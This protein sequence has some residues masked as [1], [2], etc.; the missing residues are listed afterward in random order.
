M[1]LAAPPL[2][3]RYPWGWRRRDSLALLLPM[4]EGVLVID[5]PLGTEL[6]ARGVPTPLPGWSAHALETHPEVVE[7]VHRDYARAGAR[8]HTTNTFRTRSRV[9]PQQ[10]ELLARRAVELARRAVC[11]GQAEAPAGVRIAGSIAPLED[12]Y[13][14]DLSPARSDVAACRREH[15][16]L[17][18]V[19][20]DAGSDLLLCETFPDI[21]EGL[22][23]ARA[24]RETGL[25]TWLSFTPGPEG[26][27]LSP[28][29]V[30]EGAKRAVDLGVSAVLV[31]C[32]PARSALAF[33][34]AIA[35]ALEGS[36]VRLGCYANAGQPDDLMGWTSDPGAPER[37]VARVREW[38]EA[39]ARIVGGCCGTSISHV[40]ALAREFAS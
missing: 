35:E 19:L 8:L 27:L 14:P 5:G 33:V 16:A 28:R 29:D 3:P 32:V 1:V 20:A 15:G 30:S 7:G 2:A 4:E 31:N 37:Y 17:A 26:D 10:W 6:L 34:E 21:A 18:A 25:E 13:R 9:F 36:E 22:T 24:A 11:D 23:A 40:A 39:G 12:C 38:V